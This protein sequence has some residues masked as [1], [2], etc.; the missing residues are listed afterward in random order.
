MRGKSEGGA[1]VRYGDLLG[2]FLMDCCKP[3]TNTGLIKSL[4]IELTSAFAKMNWSN[5]SFSSLPS[6]DC[7]PPGS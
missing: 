5:A 2:F 1:S 3:D 7:V 6:F 4:K